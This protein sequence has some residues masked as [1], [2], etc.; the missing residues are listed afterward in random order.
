[1]FICFAVQGE[2]LKVHH[3]LNCCPRCRQ[4]PSCQALPTF[5]DVQLVQNTQ[6]TLPTSAVE[7]SLG[8]RCSMLLGACKTLTCA[9]GDLRSCS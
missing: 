5:L 8:H 6:S 9:V 1:M 3:C 2:L 7:I 4:A